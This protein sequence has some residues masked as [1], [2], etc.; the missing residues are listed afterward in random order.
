[1]KKIIILC[2]CILLSGCT[3]NSDSLQQEID[4]LRSENEILVNQVNEYASK[5]EKL[6]EENEQLVTKIESSKDLFEENE[7]LSME[8]DLCKSQLVNTAL[9]RS[10]TEVS[11]DK[12][13][14][15][16]YVSEDDKCYIIFENG[17]FIS[18][19]K[20]DGLLTTFGGTWYIKDSIL[21]WGS[22]T[23]SEYSYKI[24][25]NVLYLY[26]DYQQYEWKKLLLD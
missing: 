10:K 20:K 26:N 5:I 13:L 11:T 6:E 12:D 22:N 2:I 16:I 15:G 3:R 23:V 21:Y 4:Q 24:K 9:L 25:N 14:P 1:M 17:W 19:Y 8:L 7:A 18:F